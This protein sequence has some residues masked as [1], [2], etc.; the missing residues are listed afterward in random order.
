MTTTTKHERQN[1][2]LKA[3]EKHGYAPVMKRG[4][5]LKIRCSKCY[6]AVVESYGD[7]ENAW[8]D[9]A[10]PDRAIVL[11]KKTERVYA[12][13]CG[14]RERPVIKET[15]KKCLCGEAIPKHRTKYCLMCWPSNA[16]GPINHESRLHELDRKELKEEFDAEVKQAQEEFE[17]EEPNVVLSKMLEDSSVFIL[18][19]GIEYLYRVPLNVHPN[20]KALFNHNPI[21]ALAFIKKSA[22]G[23][24]IIFE[25]RSKV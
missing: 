8:P 24:P 19:D 20:I 4:E 22:N 17:K 14:H 6:E 16:N 2:M 25:K 1:A 21:K 10:D 12:C 11:A 23:E 13:T 3:A 5:Y 15:V 7:D 18:V 9:W